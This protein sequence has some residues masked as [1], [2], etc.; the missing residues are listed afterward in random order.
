M[1]EIA[2]RVQQQARSVAADSNSNSPGYVNRGGALEINSIQGLYDR[3][4]RAGV[5]FSAQFATAGGLAT[6]ENNTAIDL[7]EPFFRLTVPASKAIIPIQ[8]KIAAAVVWETGDEVV[9]FA[10]DTDTYNTGGAAATVR[11]M[12]IDN[13][14]TGNPASSAASSVFDGDSA[15]TESTL[16]NPRIIDVH[17]FLTGGLHLPYEYNI[18]KGDPWT[19]IHGPASFGVMLARTTT[20]VEVLY[21]VKW[22]EIDKNE[23]VNS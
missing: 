7:T 12:F 22:A 14:G 23:L 20:T 13:Q 10:G 5:V 8:V 16:T 3:W 15:L 2:G 6:I 18:L 9:L 1:T 19:Y 4:V 17:H 21:T 11:S